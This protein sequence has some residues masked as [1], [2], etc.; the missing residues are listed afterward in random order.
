MSILF[1]SCSI[2]PLTVKNRFIRSA[3]AEGRGDGQGGVTTEILEFY[4][5]LARGNLGTIVTG[6]M[7]VRQDGKGSPIALGIDRDELVPGLRELASTIKENGS[8]AIFQL[9]HAGGQAIARVTGGPPRSASADSRLE[10]Q[11]Q[12]M[13]ERLPL[14]AEELPGIVDAFAMAAARARTAGADGVQL[15]AAH[16]YLL[17]EFL[18]PASNRR[19]DEYGVNEAG[20]YRLLHEVIASVRQAIGDEMALLV[21]MNIVDGVPDPAMDPHLAA[22]YAGFMARD[23]V[24]CLELSAGGMAAPFIMVRGER[25]AEDFAGAM[26][27]PFNHLLFDLYDATPH[28]P[29]VEAYNAEGAPAVKAALGTIPLAVVGGMRTLAAMNR[30]IDDGSADLISLSRPLVREPNLVAKYAADPTTVPRCISC[31]KCMAAGFHGL[32][33]RCYVSGLPGEAGASARALIASA[34]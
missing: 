16:G 32:P 27:P 7:F 20:R 19:D 23:G 12:L 15:H 14:E 8:R 25:H 11:R 9:H 31:N 10:F 34:E 30:C 33:T 5:R 28:P 22:T 2:G 29:F 18:S 4:S 21:K 26:P 1:D 13:G 17:G 6:F 24:D 3:T